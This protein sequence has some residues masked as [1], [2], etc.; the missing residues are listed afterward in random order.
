MIEKRK[1]VLPVVLE[2]Q[3]RLKNEK[4][5]SPAALEGQNPKKVQKNVLPDYKNTYREKINQNYY[6]KELEK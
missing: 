6:F 5:V 1:S 4:S 2:G 3:N